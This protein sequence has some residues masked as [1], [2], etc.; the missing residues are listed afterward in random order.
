MAWLYRPV[1]NV[2]LGM[3]YRVY[4][5]SFYVQP[6][7]S[8]EILSSAKDYHRCPWKHQ[9]WACASWALNCSLVPSLS[10]VNN[11]CSC[12]PLKLLTCCFF[13]NTQGWSYH[14]SPA[15]KS[16]TWEEGVTRN[17]SQMCPALG[18]SLIW[19]PLHSQSSYG[20]FTRWIRTQ[21]TPGGEGGS[22]L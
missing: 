19:N 12:I 20:F 14:L 11:E 13:G 7:R 10:K 17:Q 16:S 21:I 6:C 2:N 15:P 9:H 8:W 4:P 3:F 5:V 22:H 1:N 18:L